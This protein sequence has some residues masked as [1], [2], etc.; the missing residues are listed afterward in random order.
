MVTWQDEP[1][2]IARAQLADLQDGWKKHTKL[3]RTCR[4]LTEIQRRY[5]DEGWQTAKA[6][7]QAQQ[8]VTELKPPEDTGQLTLF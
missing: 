5:C 2:R 4:K 1:L 8:R 7:R 3:C 6:I